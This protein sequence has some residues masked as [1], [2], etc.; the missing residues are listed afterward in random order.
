MRLRGISFLYR[1]I[2]LMN[3]NN[4]KDV[5]AKRKIIKLYS[6][7]ISAVKTLFTKNLTKS[8]NSLSK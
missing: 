7:P 8:F 5:T 4:A 2:C 3:V 6:L 1:I